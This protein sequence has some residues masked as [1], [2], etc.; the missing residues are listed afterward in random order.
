MISYGI[1]L[2]EDS[3]IKK[4]KKKPLLNSLNIILPKCTWFIVVQIA[5]RLN[6][7]YVKDDKILK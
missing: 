4:K 6:L 3:H 7:N 1:Q 2:K 5:H